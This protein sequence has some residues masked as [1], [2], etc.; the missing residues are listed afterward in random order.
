MAGAFAGATV[1]MLALIQL[2]RARHDP[3]HPNG[4]PPLRAPWPSRGRIEKSMPRLFGNTH[5]LVLVA[6]IAAS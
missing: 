5:M 6:V 2:R 4:P 1:K 3:N